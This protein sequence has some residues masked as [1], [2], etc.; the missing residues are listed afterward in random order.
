MKNLRQK[1]K[2]INLKHF[3]ATILIVF[4]LYGCGVPVPEDKSSYVGEWKKQRDV[5]AHSPGWE[6]GL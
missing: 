4:F 1:M 2:S 3:T 6:C 5:F